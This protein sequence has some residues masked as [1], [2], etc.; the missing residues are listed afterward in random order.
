M[1]RAS[2]TS[3]VGLAST[4]LH[5]SFINLQ[6]ELHLVATAILTR[7]LDLEPAS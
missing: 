5:K 2:Q 7:E 1:G 6:K 3:S 4:T